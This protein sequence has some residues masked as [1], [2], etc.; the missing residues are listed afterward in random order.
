[1]PN[2][3]HAAADP[4]DPRARRRVT[5]ECKNGRTKQSFKDE[6]DINQILAQWIKTKVPPFMDGEPLYGDFSKGTDFQKAMNQV[7]DAEQDFRT[8][9]SYIRERFKND[10]ARL[11]E[12]L[13]DDKNR[14]E[15]EELG[16]IP[17]PEKKPEK[18]KA[19]IVPTNT[20]KTKT[21]EKSEGD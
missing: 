3:T 21:P 7:V 1:M 19:T 15:A 16:I 5:T 20:P 10:P 13:E 18:A 9:P 6:S 11:L 2:T 14:E 17:K 12:F 4:S 8:L